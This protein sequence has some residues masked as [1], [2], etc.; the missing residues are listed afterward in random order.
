MCVERMKQCDD[1]VALSKE[2]DMKATVCKFVEP[3]KPLNHHY[4]SL[5]DNADGLRGDR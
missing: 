5:G 4:G 3:A 1:I 2:L